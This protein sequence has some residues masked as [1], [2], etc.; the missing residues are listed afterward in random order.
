[1]SLNN[2]GH[3]H[4]SHTEN[5]KINLFILQNGHG[6]EI[7]AKYRIRKRKRELSHVEIF[8]SLIPTYMERVRGQQKNSLLDSGMKITLA[9]VQS[10]P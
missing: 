7:K 1:M 5:R 3:E 2:S 10:Q 8:C 6:Y 9:F 4:G